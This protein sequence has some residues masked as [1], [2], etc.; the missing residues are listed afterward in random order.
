MTKV[1]KGKQKGK[2]NKET[3]LWRGNVLTEALNQGYGKSLANIDYDTP[4]FEML[5]QLQANIWS[6]SAAADYQQLKD[7]NA[8]LVDKEGKQREFK[9]FKAEAEKIGKTYNNKRLQVEYNHAVATSQMASNWVGYQLNEDIAPNLKYV[10]VGDS[11]V[12]QAHKA[13]DG[14]IRPLKDAFWD[15]YYPP[16]DWGCRCDTQAVD[17]EPNE[18]KHALPTVPKMFA[19]NLA[20]SGV[21]YPDGHPYFAYEVSQ[22]EQEVAEAARSL[23]AKHTRAFT[24]ANSE[25][26]SYRVNHLDKDVRAGK[27]QIKTV[28]GKRHNNEPLRNMLANNIE[29]VFKQ[30]S[31]IRTVKDNKPLQHKDTYMD[32]YYYGLEIGENSFFINIG[33]RK[34][35][36]FELHAIT[37]KLK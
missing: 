7:L 4:D 17:G 28:T 26:K 19:T 22:D 11:L 35:G 32:W 6:F 31:F 8:A 18:V 37:D 36:T 9:D 1:F 23:Y 3:T 24:R 2:V 33:K 20:K 29:Q 12:R 14:I 15:T 10:T 30:M 5:R 25:N 16:N 27:A 21:L 13:L 34:D